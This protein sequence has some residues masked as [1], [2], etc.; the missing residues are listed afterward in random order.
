M[1]QLAGRVA[2]ITG[3]NSGIGRATA[4]LF[5]AEGARVVIAARNVAKGEA[6]TAAIRAAGGEARFFRC[7]VRQPEDCQ[8]AVDA[9]ISAY[10]KL[11]ILFNNAG[12]V[13]IGSVLET[14]VELW[15]DTFATNVHGMFYTTRAALPH[16]IAARGVIVNM[17]SDWGVV[18]GQRAAL[19]S[20]TK[21]AVALF[22][23]SLALDYGRQ[24]VRVNAIC[25]GD[26]YVERWRERDNLS[27]EQVEIYLKRLGEGFALGRV[28][29]VEEIARAVLFL[30]SDASSYM[31]G[32]LLIVDG[33]NTAGGTSAS[34]G[35]TDSSA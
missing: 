15:Q 30:A 23:K 12:V 13:P 18:G 33:G 11:D 4:E 5:A 1:A 19:Y 2:L 6:T 32:Q 34:F 35:A 9:A 28:G 22:T 20:A 16:L 29:T 31:T 3:G 17:A 21:G 8:Q 27:S 26:T 24:G 7:D 14:S 25:P 10:G